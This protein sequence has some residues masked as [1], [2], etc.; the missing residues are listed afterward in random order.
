ML[1]TRERYKI[2][3]KILN[4]KRVKRIKIHILLDLHSVGAPMGHPLQLM[5]ILIDSTTLSLSILHNI[6]DSD[7]TLSLSPT[8]SPTLAQTWTQSNCS[9]RDWE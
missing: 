4:V 6:S 5:L 1:I 9:A 2:Y 8:L 3:H 7:S